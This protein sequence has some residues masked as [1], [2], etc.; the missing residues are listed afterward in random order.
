MR[1]V[2]HHF[3]GRAVTIEIASG[4][5]RTHRLRDTFLE[6]VNDSTEIER[7]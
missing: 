1:K 4:W 5:F 7:I 3:R 6:P 2:Y